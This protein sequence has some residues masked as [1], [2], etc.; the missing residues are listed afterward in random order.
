MSVSWP[1][2]DQ[3]GYRNRLKCQYTPI[4]KKN[5]LL[6]EVLGIF[7]PFFIFI[8]LENNFFKP[9]HSNRVWKIPYFFFKASLREGFKKNKKK[10]WIYPYL[11]GWVFQDGDKIHK[12][13]KKHAFNPNR[14]GLLDVA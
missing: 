4:L 12:K 8:F 7:R 3:F 9:T 1:V 13:Q 6:N 10:I 5:L 11:G 14:A 2:I